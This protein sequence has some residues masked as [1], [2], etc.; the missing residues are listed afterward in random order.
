MIAQLVVDVGS[1]LS[2]YGLKITVTHLFLPLHLKS[3]LPSK[4][5]CYIPV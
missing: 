4:K 1:S 5:I 2:R 3:L